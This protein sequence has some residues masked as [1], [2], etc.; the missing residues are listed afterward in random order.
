MQKRTI[1]A[2]A[3]AICLSLAVLG[4]AA[5]Q[6][7]VVGIPHMSN[8]P[9]GP[10]MQKFPSGTDMVY[11]VFD[12]ETEA[13]A[14]IVAE[15]RSEAQQGSVLFTSRETYNGTGTA[16][17]EV[18]GPDS[19][20]FPDGVYDTIIR[21]GEDRFV[22]AGWEWTVGDVE[23]PPEDTSGG[24]A[25]ISPRQESESAAQPDA[26]AE[27]EMTTSE[28]IEAA[29]PAQEAPAPGLSPV[30]LAIVAIIVVVLLTIIIWAVRGFMTAEH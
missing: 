29:T 24:Q 21:F 16:N 23:L 28:S 2:F 6:S 27:S 7:P 3:I 30:M 10:E 8:E 1:K 4:G 25:P 12:Y 18:P 19:N 14:E 9:D 20:A 26:G 15:I 22:T 11:V 17:I 13:A 5:A